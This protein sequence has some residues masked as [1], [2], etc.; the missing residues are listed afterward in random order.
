MFNFRNAQ[1]SP[2]MSENMANAIPMRSK[3]GELRTI[4]AM[5]VA[6]ERDNKISII[7][8]YDLIF[9]SQSLITCMI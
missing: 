9:N 5:N 1:V 2:T 6:P 7:A 8:E 3:N 4:V